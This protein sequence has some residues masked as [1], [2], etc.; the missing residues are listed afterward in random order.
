MAD[1]LLIFDGTCGVCS[2]AADWLSTR[3]EPSRLLALPNQTPGLLK[4]TGLTRGEVDRAV[5]LTDQQ[6][7]RF[8]GAAAV[9][10]ALAQCKRGPWAL[11]SRLY[12]I[13]GVQQIEDIVYAW[14]AIHRG[15]LAILGAVPACER[16]GLDCGPV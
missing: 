7:N 9:N 10:R 1:M 5:W 4:A 16:A 2:R 3:N 12:A 11:V 13:R 14:I 6:G 15:R 8:S